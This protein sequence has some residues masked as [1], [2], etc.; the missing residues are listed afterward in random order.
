M[1]KTVLFF[2]PLLLSFFSMAQEVSDTAT[3]EVNS[4]FNLKSN[5]LYDATATFNLG[6]EFRLNDRWS[7]DIPFSYNPFTFSNNRKWKHFLVQPELRW[8]KNETFEGQFWGIHTH[9]GIYNVAAL[10]S[11]P[12]SQNM[13]NNRYEGSLIG[14]GVSYGYRWNISQ[15]WGMEATIGVGYAYLDH[16]KY[17]CVKCGQDLG[18][19]NKHYFGPTKIGLSLIYSFGGMKKQVIPSSVSPTIVPIPEPIIAAPYVPQLTASF[20]IPEAE[21]VKVRSES[22]K[23]YLDYPVGKA[24][25]DINYKANESELQRIY[26]LIDDIYNDPDASITNIEI[27]GFASPE[28]GSELNRQ[29]SEKRA[30]A[31]QDHLRVKYSFSDELITVN[32]AGEDW[33]TLENLIN[34]S[35]VELKDTILEII[36]S[37]NTD[38]QKEKR[39]ASLGRVYSDIKENYFPQLRRSD[40]ALYY[41]V[42]PF[43][44]EKGKEIFKTKP[45]ALS[46]NELFLIANTYEVGSS[47]YNEVFE[48]AAQLYPDNDVANLNAC[49]NALNRGDLTS[50]RKYI[51][52]IKQPSAAY[53]NNRGMLFAMEGEWEKAEVDF[54]NAVQI[55]GDNNASHNMEELNKRN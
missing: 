28:G 35:D 20:V 11:G 7:L 26:T 53:Y 51:S 19:R 37:E 22:G 46:L 27:T 45:S 34:E 52:K 38:D 2:M 47:A 23:A 18:N 39:L 14:A 55:G 25:I 4:N 24:V 40:Y 16:N 10:P 49:A 41:T 6:A 3:Y 5:L 43:T 31:L 48:T 17:P 44:I 54:K 33:E 36:Q 21:T 50:A 15:R 42:L 9:Y 32:G 12:F 30:Y 29:L 8:W 13:K 1:K